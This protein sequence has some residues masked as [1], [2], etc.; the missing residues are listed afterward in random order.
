MTNNDIFKQLLSLFEWSPSKVVEV[1]GILSHEIEESHVQRWLVAVKDPNFLVMKDVELSTFLNALICDMRGKK[2]GPQPVPEKKISNNIVM[3]KLKIALN[4][5]NE[6]LLQ[7]FSLSG[8]TL[9]PYELTAF[10]RK[11]NHKNYR[12]MK[13]AQLRKFIAGLILQKRSPTTP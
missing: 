10:F 11:P 7:V 5:Q 2:E 12:A 1:H 13:D 4:L 8:V 9:S 6:D 3:K